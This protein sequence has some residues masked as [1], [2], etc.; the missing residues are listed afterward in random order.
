MLPESEII[1]TSAPLLRAWF[2]AQDPAVQLHL[3][4]EAKHLFVSESLG[5]KLTDLDNALLALVLKPSDSE[6]E[7]QTSAFMRA[8][9]EA[10]E[11]LS[12][13]EKWMEFG[14]ARSD[15]E[16]DAQAAYARKSFEGLQRSFIEAATSYSSLV[17]SCSRAVQRIS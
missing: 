14:G 8:F 4:L 15:S 12:T 17:A 13:A 3:A 7:G 1:E 2:L 16:T 6:T 9:A 10:L 11:P 5:E